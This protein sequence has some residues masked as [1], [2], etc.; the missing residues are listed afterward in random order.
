M[1]E[2]RDRHDWSHLLGVI[3]LEAGSLSPSSKE[4]LGKGRE[5]ADQLGVWLVV[6]SPTPLS[7]Q[8]GQIISHGADVVLTTPL[9]PSR[10]ENS[11][12]SQQLM[13]QAESISKVIE[14]EHPEI[15]LFTSSPLVMALAARVAQHFKTGLAT[16][17]ISLTLDLAERKLLAISPLHEGKLLEEYHW[18]I[19]RPQMASLRAGI[20][21]EAFPDVYREGTIKTVE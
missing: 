21:P 5:L 4:L 6:Y 17:C 13:K 20:F 9:P 10:D 18:P 7:G 8:E 15:V 19:K 1:D 12:S 11:F 3:D 16:D 14:H 2:K